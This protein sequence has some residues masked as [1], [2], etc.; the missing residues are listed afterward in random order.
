MIGI[1]MAGGKSTRMQDTTEK[2]LL[3][4]KKPVI[5]RVADAM[6]QSNCFDEVIVATSQNAPKT[7]A[8]LESMEIRTV[9]TPGQGYANDLSSILQ[10]INDKVMVVSG[11]MPLLDPSII[12]SIISGYDDSIWHSILVSEK[13]SESLGLR[14]D[15]T[16][17]CNDTA[18]RFSGVSVIDAAKIQ[19][20][21]SVA[22]SYRILNDKRIAFNLNTKRDY[23][24]LGTI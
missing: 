21:G 20:S 17:T 5:L 14:H 4:Y 11:D 9:Q 18:C 1:I 12:K 7:R 23:D 16:V 22:E 6:R 24:L 10:E 3:E 2:L 19:S 15:T 13:F 8:L